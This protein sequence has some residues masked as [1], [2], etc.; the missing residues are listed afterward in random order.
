MTNRII[1]LWF[2]CLI[3]ICSNKILADACGPDDLECQKV[4]AMEA[5]GI[6]ALVT[7]DP[8]KTPDAKDT[9]NNNGSQPFVLPLPSDNHRAA[10]N[11]GL[12][13]VPQNQDPE[14]TKAINEA[15]QAVNKAPAPNI[16]IP[17]IPPTETKILN[18]PSVSG[19]TPKD[20]QGS[21]RAIYVPPSPQPAPS[22]YK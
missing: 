13:L 12:E 9:N 11:P 3:S 17:K 4:K 22:I 6:Q 18:I 14:V 7:K 2:F 5:A 19:A 21:D 1:S 20:K 10:T 15:K 16:D 8:E